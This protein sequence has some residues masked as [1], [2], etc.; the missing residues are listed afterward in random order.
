M[1]LQK[2]LEPFAQVLVIF[3]FS[4]EN[5]GGKELSISSIAYIIFYLPWAKG[6]KGNGTRG[7][8]LHYKGTPFHRIIPGFMIQ[9]GD[10]FRGDGKGSESI[11]GGKFPD[12]NF[13]IKHS[14]AGM[15]H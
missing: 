10:I 9:G 12:E 14:H 5:N 3:F 11:Y 8:P 6:E 13:I 1:V 15:V 2:I 4:L 7:K